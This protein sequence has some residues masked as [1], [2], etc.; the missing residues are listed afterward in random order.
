MKCKQCGTEMRREY[1]DTY[2][3]PRCYKTVRK[4]S[5]CSNDDDDDLATSIAVGSVFSSFSDGGGFD[6]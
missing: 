3:C 2:K 4:T 1:G 6:F 5:G